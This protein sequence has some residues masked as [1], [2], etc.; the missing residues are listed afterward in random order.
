MS[1]QRRLL[2]HA[3]GRRDAGLPDSGARPDVD[4]I[5]IRIY[6]GAKQLAQSYSAKQRMVVAI[7]DALGWEGFELQLENE[8]INWKDPSFSARTLGGRSFS[9]VRGSDIRQSWMNSLRRS[10]GSESKN[11]D[12]E[13]VVRIRVSL[14]VRATALLSDLTA[15]AVVGSPCSVSLVPWISKC[16]PMQSMACPNVSTPTSFRPI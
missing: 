13:A 1:C 6:E 15:L 11:M 10:V 2:G 3:P 7:V 8:W 4:F 12:C 16:L 9:K 5:F 14:G